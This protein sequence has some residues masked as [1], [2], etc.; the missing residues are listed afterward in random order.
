MLSLLEKRVKS[1]DEVTTM[2]RLPR[3]MKELVAEY[4]KT[5]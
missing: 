5:S 4:G 1:A 2:E 3:H